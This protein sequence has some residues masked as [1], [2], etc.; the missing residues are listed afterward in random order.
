MSNKRK[1]YVRVTLTPAISDHTT[2]EIVGGV[3]LSPD[4][5]LRGQYDLLR[6]TMEQALAP[7][8][9]FSWS[10]AAINAAVELAILNTYPRGVSYFVEVGRGVMDEYVQVYHP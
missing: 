4:R 8:A 6:S 10:D 2:I 9:L 3:E 7:G 1:A 5:T